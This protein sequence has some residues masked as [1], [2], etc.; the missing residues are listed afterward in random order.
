MIP[1]YEIQGE[2]PNISELI[3]EMKVGD[4]LEE[5]ENSGVSSAEKEFLKKAAYRHYVFDYRK[6][7][8][9]YAAAS[10]EMQ[11]L[12]EKSALVIIDY[13]DAIMNGYSKLTEKIKQMLEDSKK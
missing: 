12:M 1:Q 4:L 10:E 13:E 5:I 6:I 3:Q 2:T 8:E 9:Y 11:Q 7:A